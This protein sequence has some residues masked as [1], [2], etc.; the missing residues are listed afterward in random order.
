MSVIQARSADHFHFRN[1]QGRKMRIKI[2]TSDGAE[3]LNTIFRISEK[4]LEKNF[5]SQQRHELK[6]RAYRELGGTQREVIDGFIQLYRDTVKQ[7]HRDTYDRTNNELIQ[8]ISGDDTRIRIVWGDCSDVLKAMESESV[9]LM[10]TSPPYFNAREY[11]QWD[12]LDA[13][14]EDMH[15]VIKES[16]RV[17]DNHRPFVFNV[18]DIFDNDHRYT[19]SSWGKRRIPLG[20]YFIKIFEDC[21]YQ[22]VDDFI[23]DK[24][25]VQTQRHK[26]AGN[27]YPLYQ[28]PVNCYEHIFVF[29]KHRLDTFPYPCPICGCLKVNGN[30]YSSVGVKSW[31][32]K[33]L[34]CMER[35]AGN[36]GKRFSNR[37]YIMNGL[38]ES[39]NETDINLLKRWRRDIV[40]INPVIKINSQK[41]NI[42]GHTAPFPSEIPAYAINVFTGVNETVM[43]PFAGSFTTP[44]EAHRRGRKS[45]GVELNK[46][47]FRNSILANIM[48]NTGLLSATELDYVG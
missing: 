48:K 4:Y 42:I 23:W 13:Y 20:A 37:T 46:R 36:R 11:S 47:M 3:Y 14:L 32:C 45:I 10:I 17:L 26:N 5:S 39:N 29:F 2:N 7:I 31:E 25:E 44:I 8:F 22:F 12:T 33:N 41:K 24:G 30:A 15:N 16:Y 9:Q 34:E 21:G 35:S 1:V 43:D 40:Q 27:P 19:R 18:G 6:N 38:K 28:Y